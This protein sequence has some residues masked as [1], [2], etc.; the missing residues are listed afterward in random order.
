M[1]ENK[2]YRVVDR[3]SN[4]N[5]FLLDKETNKG[6][7][8]L[9]DG[10][11][12]RLAYFDLREKKQTN[13]NNNNNNKTKSRLDKKKKKY[14]R[15]LGMLNTQAFQFCSLRENILGNIRFQPCPQGCLKFLKR[16]KPWE[17]G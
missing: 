4:R 9:I 12:K 17:R 2:K 8:K 6:K 10:D 7:N 16:E 11:N 14:S 5:G 3:S 1:E 15:K 13:N